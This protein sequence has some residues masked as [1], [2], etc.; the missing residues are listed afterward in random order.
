MPKRYNRI[1]TQKRLIFP[2][3]K[4]ETYGVVLQKSKKVSTP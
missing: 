1:T 2:S 4:L 3:Q